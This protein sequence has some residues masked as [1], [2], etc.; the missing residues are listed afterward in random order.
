MASIN[1]NYDPSIQIMPEL[2]NELR[3]LQRAL[4]VRDRVVNQFVGM[5]QNVEFKERLQ[6]VVDNADRLVI[7][8]VKR[9][10]DWISSHHL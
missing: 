2:L 4:D 5:N 3:Q 8:A 1:F 7:D 6:N 9:T 10:F